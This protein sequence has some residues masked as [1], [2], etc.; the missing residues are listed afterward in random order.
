M[1]CDDVVGERAERV[2]APC[3][4]RR[5]GEAARVSW[6]ARRGTRGR[7]RSS[8]N[9]VG[10]C[11]RAVLDA[12]QRPR[13]RAACSRG[14]G[15]RRPRTRRSGRPRRRPWRRSSSIASAVAIPAPPWA[16]SYANTWCWSGPPSSVRWAIA[17]AI[18]ASAVSMAAVGSREI[19][20]RHGSEPISAVNYVHGTKGP[21]RSDRRRPS[22]WHPGGVASIC[23]FC[24]A[25]PGSD[26][27]VGEAAGDARSR[28]RGRQAT[29]SC[30][31]VGGSD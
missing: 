13:A 29:V 20:R 31:A 3:P 14:R 27:A 1:G 15:R 23:V 21:V 19:G 17:L 12:P 10:G 9:S 30:T 28:D 7:G 4:S 24:G 25:N 18:T 26:P 11:E 2:A 22:L 6:R 8:T 16:R 5:G